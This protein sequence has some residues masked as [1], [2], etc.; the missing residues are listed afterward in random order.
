MRLLSL[1]CLALSLA[2]CSGAEPIAPEPIGAPA[3][4]A[5]TREGETITVPEGSS[6]RE[7]L[8]VETLEARPIRRSLEAPAHVEADPSRIARITPPLAGRVVHLFVRFGEEVVAGQ[9]LLSLDSP[10]LV[11]A[12]TEALNARAALAQAELFYPSDATN[13]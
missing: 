4:P 8:V 5:F 1:L 3:G 9:P 6:L 7:R 2:S 11:T 13:L 12:Q 10:E